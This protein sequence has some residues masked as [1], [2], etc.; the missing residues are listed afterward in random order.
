MPVPPG[1]LSMTNCWPSNSVTRCAYVRAT[2]SAL[3]PALWAMIRRIGLVGYADWAVAIRGAQTA[4]ASVKAST[5]TRRRLRMPPL[6]EGLT[7]VGRRSRV[8]G[9]Q[10]REFDQAVFGGGRIDESD[11]AAG[12]T[13]ARHLIEQRDAFGFEFGERLVDVLDFKAD[14]IEPAFAFGDHL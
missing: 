4:P 11:A 8:I 1:R 3:P 9:G 7:C 2:K 13:E 5:Q 10:L 12:V 14:V 6:A